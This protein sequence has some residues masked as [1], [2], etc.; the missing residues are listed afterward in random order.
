M[1][2]LSARR[3]A[4]LVINCYVAS[5]AFQ[6]GG[7]APYRYVCT[8]Q[9]FNSNTDDRWRENKHGWWQKWAA[10]TTQRPHA[11][12]V[13]GSEECPSGHGDVAAQ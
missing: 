1:L 10:A 2:T 12:V 9:R 3:G 13:E 11:V 7:V 5:A 8:K 4:A 6:A